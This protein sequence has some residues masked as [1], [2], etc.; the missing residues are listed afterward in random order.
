MGI[1]DKTFR[2]ISDSPDYRHL[3]DRDRYKALYDEVGTVEANRQI[4]WREEWMKYF[5]PRPGATILEL[6]SHNGPNLL[7][8]SRLGHSTYGVEVSDTLTDTFDAALRHEPAE[9]QSRIHLHRG[10]IED[11]APEPRFDEVLCTEILE[12]V[13][14]PVAVLKVA[15]LGLKPGGRIYISSPFSHWGN[16]THVRGVPTGDLRQWLDAAGLTP[17]EIWCEDDRT[18]CIA[19]VSNVRVTGMIRVRNETAI[20]T[21]T[22]DHLARFCSGG[23]Y[24]Y[25][26]VSTDETASLCASHPWVRE[27]IRGA[28]WDSNRGRA[29]YENRAAVLKAAQA[30]AGAQDWLVYL[31]AD[32]RIEFNWSDLYRQPDDVI[33]VRMKLFDFYITPDDANLIYHQRQWMGPEFRPIVIAFRNLPSLQFRHL[34]QREV[35]LGCE[36]R[37]IEAGFVKH[38]G[39]AI[40]IEQWEH[41]CDYYRTYFPAYAAK[42][43]AR[44][45]KAIHTK[46]DFGHDLIRWEQKEDRGVLLTPEIEKASQ[47][48]NQKVPPRGFKILLATHQLLDFT[49]SELFTFTLAD[50][51]KRHGHE[52]TVYSPYVDR[53]WQRFESIR[54]R[55]VENLDDL[56]GDTFDLAHVHHNIT[57]IEVRRCFPSL[58]MVFLSHGVLPFLEQPPAI[59]LQITRFLAVS[60]EV[61]AALL[62]YGIPENRVSIF[63][64]IVD[65]QR[66]CPSSVL[67]PVPERALII[68]ARLDEQ[69]ENIIREACALCGISP[70]FHG[71]R[72]GEIDPSH[73]PLL[74]NNADIVFSLGRGAIEAMMCGRIPVVFD[75]LGGDGMVTPDNLQELMTCNFS[76]RLCGRGYTVDELVSEIKKYRAENGIALR[77]LA[78]SFFDAYKRVLDLIGV[79]SECIRNDMASLPRTEERLLN[80][81]GET[82]RETRSYTHNRLA[83]IQPKA[84]AEERRSEIPLPT[85]GR[86]R[87]EWCESMR[88][89]ES[90]L[91]LN[92]ADP[93]AHHELGLLKYHDGDKLQA[94]P[95]FQRAAAL[96]PRNEQIRQ[97]LVILYREIVGTLM[98]DLGGKT[99]HVRNLEIHARNLQADISRSEA[100]RNSLLDE[101]KG[102]ER[103]LERSERQRERLEQERERLVV[104]CARL[105]KERAGLA[106]D[107]TRSTQE[108][109]RSERERQKLQLEGQASELERQ[110]LEGLT[111]SQ[112]EQLSRFRID[113]Y[114]EK[115]TGMIERIQ[116]DG[117]NEVAVYGAGEA[118]QA[119]ISLC[120][121]H[122]IR[123]RC[124]IDRNESLWGTRIQGIPVLP[125]AEAIEDGN[126]V[127]AVASFAFSREISQEI[128][129][130]YEDTLR[131]P[132]I[133]VPNGLKGARK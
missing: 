132:R 12:H 29:E 115:M 60:E 86:D 23:I 33:A 117:F 51:L 63:R 127:Y 35:E 5:K 54:V 37:I 11:F 109:E 107:L 32:E 99:E 21:D 1:E 40:S 64:N 3:Q 14:D 73:L 108:Y 121:Q 46:S 65:S 13:A 120:R 79:Y 129:A 94:L 113:V 118:G 84:R 70:T 31:D 124:A 67:R 69:R 36:G 7:H 116:R 20:I 96:A 4:R 62:G 119:L 52:V 102:L 48:V 15:R 56:R 18:F 10:W 88:H 103:Q 110:R 91:W 72:F 28:Y 133:Y 92:E 26:D 85:S 42:W 89:V 25:D 45:G 39:K 47:V 126:D 80:A 106:S 44:K 90:L 87:N 61:Q 38:Y 75:Y 93:A 97:S 57:A 122:G 95:H 105:E 30:K 17:V 9:V 128:R 100:A 130:R 76:G 81:F 112:R 77:H 22:L 27:V 98:A 8:Y 104:E 41:T 131:K 111:E 43:A 123:I 58:P 34:D 2:Y 53:F 82:I 78:L 50:F 114:G 19:H 101:R 83:R 74:I 68:S 125:F 16:N 59:N 49:G 66:F 55:V 24:V 6:G 71:G